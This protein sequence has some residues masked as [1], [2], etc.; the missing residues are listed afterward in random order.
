MRE[1]VEKAKQQDQQDAANQD[2]DEIKLEDLPEAY[3][4]RATMMIEQLKAGGD[5]AVQRIIQ[6]YD[7]ML[8][9]LP[10]GD[11]KLTL[12]YVIQELKKAK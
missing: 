12:R 1:L 3:R 9:A 2:A 8:D 5:E 6:Q 10:E 4:Q 11:D 7:Q